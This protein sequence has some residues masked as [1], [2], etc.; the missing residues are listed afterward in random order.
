MNCFKPPCHNI[1]IP[2][3]KTILLFHSPLHLQLFHKISFSK[4]G[5]FFHANQPLPRELRRIAKKACAF[6]DAA[7]IEG[8]SGFETSF[9]TYDD[10]PADLEFFDFLQ[11]KPSPP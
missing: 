2:S 6:L 7:E 1:T 4:T 5:G 8:K 9:V 10:A 11:T 3:H